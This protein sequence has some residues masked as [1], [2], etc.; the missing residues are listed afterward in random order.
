MRDNTGTWGSKCLL[1]GKTGGQLG[2]KHVDNSE[3]HLLQFWNKM[4]DYPIY[5][6]K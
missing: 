5:Y 1:F 3:K 6:G 2:E 4:K